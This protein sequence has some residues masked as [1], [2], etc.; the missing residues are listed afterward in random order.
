MDSA[1]VQ[2]LHGLAGVQP[3]IASLTV[4]IAQFGIFILPIGL[5]VGWWMPG[6][7][8]AAHRR[9]VLAGCLAAAMAVALGL[10][11][12]RTLGRPRP[13][14][15]LGLA[16]LFPHAADSS[17]PSDHTL[18]G[19]AL[20]GVLAM[21]MPRVGIW[22]VAWAMLIGFARVMAAVHYPTDIAGSAL[23][24]L[25]LDALAILLVDQFI[26]RMPRLLAERLGLLPIRGPVAHSMS[27]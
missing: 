2:A 10:V 23:L 17:F 9:A 24:A 19:V 20:G 8:Q 12:E 3:W 25:L 18:T 21:R 13:F 22:M 26:H 6:P 16:P 11:L 4:L 1:V 7:A 14:V 15:A 5:I 27:Q